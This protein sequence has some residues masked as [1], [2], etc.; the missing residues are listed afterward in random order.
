MKNS[1]RVARTATLL[2]LSIAP[3]D[4]CLPLELPAAPLEKAM[5]YLRAR[6]NVIPWQAVQPTEIEDLEQVL[7]R[8]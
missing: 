2:F 4:L 5:F 1:T 8:G 7:V 6:D 3:I